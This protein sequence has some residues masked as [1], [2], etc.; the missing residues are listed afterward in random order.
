VPHGVG[1]GGFAAGAVLCVAG[2]ALGGR[3]VSR[4]R[5]RPDPWG[6]PE[7]AVVGSAVIGAVVLCLNLGYNPA[8]LNPGVYPLQWPSL[9]LLPT[10]AI[11]CAA[12]AAL[13]APPPPVAAAPG[14]PT[15]R[16]RVTAPASAGSKSAGSAQAAAED[17]AEARSGAG[18]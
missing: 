13:A 17:T 3:R 9:P 8:A 1:A 5:Y 12:L 14:Q 11:L 10:A 18:R 7:W 16:A 2:L 15:A 6:W 4:S